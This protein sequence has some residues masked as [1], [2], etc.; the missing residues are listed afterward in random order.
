MRVFW[1]I[2][3]SLLIIESCV[4]EQT[5]FCFLLSCCCPFYIIS[6]FVTLSKIEHNTEQ[7]GRWWGLLSHP[8]FQRKC[9]QH[10]S[11]RESLVPSLMFYH[12]HI[13]DYQSRPQQRSP[14]EFNFKVKFFHILTLQ[15]YMEYSPQLRRSTHSLQ[16]HME[17]F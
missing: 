5:Q 17:S 10:K 6:Y 14:S 15:T 13:I 4:W 8:M 3:Y 12:D 11:Y 2:L 1:Q 9:S 7:E 16:Q